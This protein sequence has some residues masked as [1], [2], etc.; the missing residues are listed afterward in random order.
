[1]FELTVE[2][3]FSAA[4]CLRGHPGRCAQLHGHNYRVVVSV[5]GETL[6]AQGMIVDFGKLKDI[7]R[8]AVDPLD[9]T[10]LNELPAFAQS[11]PT[12]E[13]LARHLHGII[14]GKL[15]GAAHGDVRLTSVTVYESDQTSA[16]YRG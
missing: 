16:T 2:V 11:N 6:N 5:A 14:G 4:H 1:M 10:L 8:S 15:A 7:C 12:A 3:P 9:H 13:A